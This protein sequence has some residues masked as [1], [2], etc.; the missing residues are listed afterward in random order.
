MHNF[1]LVNEPFL[2]TK[3]PQ[4]QF[5]ATHASMN[6]SALPRH[7]RE[8]LQPVLDEATKAR[9]KSIQLRGMQFA[10]ELADQLLK[11]GSGMESLY[12][13]LKGMLEMNQPDES[14]IQ[15]TLEKIETMQSWY[16]KAEVWC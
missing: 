2:I 9:Q 14:K 1:T 16:K 10:D 7:A 11:H 5:Q 3:H 8:L 6:H 15:N 12:T 13:E 4:K